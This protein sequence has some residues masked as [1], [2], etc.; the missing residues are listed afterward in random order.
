MLVWLETAKFLK[1]ALECH[2][3]SS[4]FTIYGNTNGPPLYLTGWPLPIPTV[5][6]IAYIIHTVYTVVSEELHAYVTST[7]AAT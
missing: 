1:L 3:T 4:D 6:V 7:H 2:P 5:L